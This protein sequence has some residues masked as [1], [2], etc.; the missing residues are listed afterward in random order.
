VNR[1]VEL[2][3]QPDRLIVRFAKRPPV[4]GGLAL[5]LATVWLFMAGGILLPAWWSGKS[6]FFGG[7][8][9]WLVLF[10]VFGVMVM[11]MFL[12]TGGSTSM[13]LTIHADGWVRRGMTA[14]RFPGP[15]TVRCV[16]PP[17]ARKGASKQLCKLQMTHGASS[18]S[19]PVL[20]PDE[21]EDFSPRITEWARQHIGGVPDTGQSERAKKPAAT[22]LTL[23][24]FYMAALLI[25]A[26]LE[27]V[28]SS[29]FGYYLNANAAPG[30]WAIGITAGFAAV[31]FIIAGWHWKQLA[32]RR[33][34][35]NAGIRWLHALAALFLI[36]AG[37]AITLRIGQFL[38]LHNQA[39]TA[40]VTL[41]QRVEA[42]TITSNGNRI[43]CRLRFYIDEP[44]LG[45]KI[46]YLADSCDRL[47]DWNRA[48]G[49]EI[50]QAENKF[51]VRILSV[52][53]ATP[54]PD[55]QPQPDR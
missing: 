38:E 55:E 40:N 2:I 11:G 31:A 3:T 8:W 52:R 45:Q 39:T 9:M 19:F 44:S 34:K 25:T 21:A 5:L 10:L 20:L 1:D 50:S 17:K 49:I 43:R 6:L 48:P 54:N 29:S 4:D 46:E 47:N 30:A 18:V 15:M 36:A 32:G 51:G 37:C 41:H 16:K 53:P 28:A 22:A 26:R 27:P 33:I 7:D 13:A 23:L 42:D 24:A 12:Q 35:A 14:W